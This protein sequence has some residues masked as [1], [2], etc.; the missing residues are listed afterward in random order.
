MSSQYNIFHLHRLHYLYSIYTLSTISTPNTDSTLSLYYL[1]YLYCN[2]ILSISLT[3][4][5]LQSH[6][7]TLGPRRETT[8]C[9]KL[10]LRQHGRGGRRE[11]ESVDMLLHGDAAAIHQ[12]KK[13]PS[14]YIPST[15]QAT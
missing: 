8:S 5:S 10:F 15:V 6:V 4:R 14:F 11:G 12:H 13:G 1:H 9:P 2:C 7:L 3:C